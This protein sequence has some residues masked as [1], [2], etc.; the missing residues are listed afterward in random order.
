VT[1]RDLA[2]DLARAEFRRPVPH[3][4]AGMDGNRD[5]AMMS[6]VAF[7]EIPALT[8][9]F[10]ADWEPFV[11]RIHAIDGPTERETRGNALL[12]DTLGLHVIRGG[13]AA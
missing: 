8:V 2:I 12:A 11:E 9:R 13:L 5:L 3:A 1:L 7:L 10:E 6:R 4:F